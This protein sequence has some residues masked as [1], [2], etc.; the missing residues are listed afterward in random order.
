MGNSQNLEGVLKG[1]EQ[2]QKII[3]A[4]LVANNAS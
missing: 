1:D 2:P 4:M 3:V